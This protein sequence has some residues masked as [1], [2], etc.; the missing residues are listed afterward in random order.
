MCLLPVENVL[1][2]FGSHES[3]VASSTHSSARL[4][5]RIAGDEKE[6]L[7]VNLSPASNHPSETQSGGSVGIFTHL[8]TSS[9]LRGL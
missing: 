2:V 5:I 4:P 1:N 8:K 3:L 7:H 9:F 6:Q